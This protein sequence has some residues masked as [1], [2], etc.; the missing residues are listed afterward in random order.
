MSDLQGSSAWP[1]R[2]LPGGFPKAKNEVGLAVLAL[3]A[4]SLLV[5]LPTWKYSYDD[6]YITY[7][8]SSNLATGSGF[9][10]QEGET[11]LATTAPL[12]ALILGVLGILSPSSIPDIGG[13]LSGAGLFAAALAIYFYSARH[14]QPLPG[15]IAG[16][17]FITF[18]MVL[19]MF[20]GEVIPF[21]ALV[22]WGFVAYD[23]EKFALTGALLGLATLMRGDG[24]IPLGLLMLHFLVTRRRIPWRLSVTFGLLFGVWGGYSYFRYGSL[25]PDT[26]SAKVAQGENGHWLPFLGG[27]VHVAKLY[28][29][30]R[31]ILGPAAHPL[32]RAYL[33]L[34]LS[35][36]LAVLL[37]ARHWLLILSWTV[38]HLVAYTA[39]GV[40]FYHWYYAPLFVAI[41]V[42]TCAALGVL[43]EWLQNIVRAWLGSYAQ[44]V[45]HTL[46]GIVLVGIMLAP[47][48]EGARIPLEGGLAI[49]REYQ[50]KPYRAVGKWLAEWSQ[51]SES[52]GYLEIGYIGYFSMRTIV[53]PLGLVTDGA[54]THVAE[55]DLAWAYRSLLP[56]YILV[57]E[58]FEGMLGPYRQE[59]WFANCYKLAASIEQIE[60][61]RRCSLVRYQ[62]RVVLQQAQPRNDQTVGEVLPDHPIGET[63]LAEDDG[64]RAVGL[65]LATYG[66]LNSGP[67]VFH[68]RELDAPSNSPDLVQLASEMTKVNNNAWKLFEF[69]PI[70]ASKGKTYYFYLEAPEA[71]PGGSITAW[72]TAGDS[73]PRG[74]L[75]INHT[76]SEGDLSFLLYYLQ[77]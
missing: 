4:A 14:G 58:A 54:T 52:V 56:D 73:F 35:G 62:D 6:A 34:V 60:V 9:V 75:M 49:Q 64:L 69:P 1:F 22:L 12:Y 66:R 2:A 20:G 77:R 21:T 13:A 30:P 42:L 37:R 11:Q 43:M 31:F 40:P 27:I 18:P 36:L 15:L 7:R 38:L 70:L 51:P 63:F 41:S 53:D 26:L 24:F 67:L 8:Y 72:S 61:Y 74:S 50:A 68:L 16:V 45:V 33:L 55:G 65:L 59:P 3:A 44:G 39:L 19:E 47:I 10:Y 48:T 29:G 46:P 5:T 76:P 32:L 71:R 17:T 57:N 25:L 28:L 23:S